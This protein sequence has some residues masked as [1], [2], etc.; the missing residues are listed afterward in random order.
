[1]VDN[2]VCRTIINEDTLVAETK[3]VAYLKQFFDLLYEVHCVKRLHQGIQMTFDQIQMRYHGITRRI[4]H[5][6]RNS[7]YIC[8]LKKTNSVNLDS[9]QL[10][11]V[12]Y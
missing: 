9:N 3:P 7:C 6:F 12:K 8:D 1:M 5:I 11:L 2:N 10:F 4:V